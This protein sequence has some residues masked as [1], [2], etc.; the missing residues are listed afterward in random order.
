MS[1]SYLSVYLTWNRNFKKRVGRTVHGPFGQIQIRWQKGVSWQMTILWKWQFWQKYIKVWHKCKQYDKGGMSIIVGFTKM[2]FC[3]IG[4]FS[5][6]FI[7][8]LAKNLNETTKEAYWQ[9][10]IFA[11][12]ASLRKR[13][14]RQES[15]KGLKKPGLRWERGDSWQMAIIIRKWQ[16]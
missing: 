2:T 4:E 11:K 15:I 1:I 6:G 3:E 7:K 8:G 12:M 16:I 14:I 5:K 10:T 13:G 9:L